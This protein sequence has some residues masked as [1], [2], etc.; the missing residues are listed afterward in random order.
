MRERARDSEDVGCMTDKELPRI[1]IVEAELVE[2]E[3]VE[4][5]DIED[6]PAVPSPESLGIDLPDSPEAG[7]D[8]LLI[9]LAESRREADSYLDDLRRVAADVDN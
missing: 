1:E 5:E 6:E 2:A 4:A 8:T 3:L 9:A 7:I